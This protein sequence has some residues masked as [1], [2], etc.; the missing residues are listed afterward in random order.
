MLYYMPLPKESQRRKGLESLRLYYGSINS[1]CLKKPLH[2]L[3][4]LPGL[5]AGQRVKLS[6]FYGVGE[7]L[8]CGGAAF[9]G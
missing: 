8:S 7:G 6:D 5:M 4:K 3:K 2:E 9:H 1:F